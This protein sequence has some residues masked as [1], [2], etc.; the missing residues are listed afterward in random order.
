MQKCSLLKE[1]E[2]HSN[3]IIVENKKQNGTKQDSPSKLA[4]IGG[5]TPKKSKIRAYTFDTIETTFTP[6][7]R[8]RVCDSQYASHIEG[9]S[10][11]SRLPLIAL[12]QG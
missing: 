1:Q 12:S 4:F 2:S 11:C 5:F 8:H 9:S 3:S 6:I 10:K 7:R